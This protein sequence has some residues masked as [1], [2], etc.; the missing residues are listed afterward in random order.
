VD[1][2]AGGGSG[3]VRRALA[4]A[5]IGLALG[6][7]AALLVALRGRPALT[8]L[9]GLCVATSPLRSLAAPGRPCQRLALNLVTLPYLTGLALLLPHVPA[10]TAFRVAHA[11][12]AAGPVLL[13]AAIAP[14]GP[15]LL[16]D[17]GAALALAVLGATVVTGALH[18]VVRPG[19]GAGRAAHLGHL[20]LAAL[21]LALGVGSNLVDTLG[22]H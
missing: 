14:G 7:L 15:P 19:R 17:A 21:W 5:A 10:R 9:G 4:A 20:G 3:P 18:L 6:G 1:A 16:P 2:T 11:L 22:R 12:A 8:D 13:L